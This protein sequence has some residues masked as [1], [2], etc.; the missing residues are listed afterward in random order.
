MVLRSVKGWADFVIM[1]W[2]A[3][4]ETAI[5]TWEK[6]TV[7]NRHDSTSSKGYTYDV[8]IIYNNKVEGT[9]AYSKKLQ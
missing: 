8:A 2:V 9:G 3:G 7:R 1:I 5:L 4:C 6:M